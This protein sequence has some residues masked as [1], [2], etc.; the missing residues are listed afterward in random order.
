M[1]DHLILLM[2]EVRT[3]LAHV[4]ERLC[5]T[6]HVSR[7]NRGQRLHKRLVS[8]NHIIALT[9]TEIIVKGKG[10]C[11]SIIVPH[12][13]LHGLQQEFVFDVVLAHLLY[14]PQLTTQLTTFLHLAEDTITE[15][16]EQKGANKP[17]QLDELGSKNSR[18]E[19][20]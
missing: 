18:I 20:N 16:H 17:E 10:L 11:L 8:A 1:V 7:G 6:I 2:I 14:L 9:L 12:S 13:Y 3:T 15:K 19:Q 5:Y 4:V